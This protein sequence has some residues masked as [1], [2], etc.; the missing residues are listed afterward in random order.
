MTKPKHTKDIL[1]EALD[2][3]GLPEMA[4]K[5]RNGWYHDFLSPLDFP[6]VQLDNDLMEAGTPEAVELSKRH[7]NGEFDASIEESEEWCNSAEG[8]T[9]IKNVAAPRRMNGG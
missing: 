6:A 5:A 3:A 2:E 8:Q 9:T 1:A 7:L 4:R